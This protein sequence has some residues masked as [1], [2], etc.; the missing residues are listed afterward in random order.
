MTEA[1]SNNQTQML[2]TFVKQGI[3]GIATIWRSVAEDD[4]RIKIIW[5]QPDNE[6]Y[7][8]SKGI[9]HFDLFA[10]RAR[11]FRLLKQYMDSLGGHATV[12]L[13]NEEFD[14]EFLNWLEPTKPIAYI[15]HVNGDHSYKAA[16]RFKAIID[17][18]YTVA[19][20][21]ASYLSCRGL[22]P[23][24]QIDY[25]INLP[26]M[27]PTKK[28][29]I[30]IY[31]GRFACDKNIKETAIHLEYF[32]SKG[33]RSIWVGNGPE[34]EVIRQIS[35]CEIITET[36]R[37]ELY[38]L[39]AKTRFLLLNS[40]YEGLPVVL[41]ECVH[42]QITP[43]LSY[44]DSSC[45]E[46]LKGSYVLASRDPVATYE[47]A[48]STNSPVSSSHQRINNSFINQ[49][50]VSMLLSVPI[51]YNNKSFR[52]DGSV[53]DRVESRPLASLV[54]RIRKTRWEFL[55]KGK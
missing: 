55:E 14:L 17:A 18:F 46:I 29:D 4:S 31:L 23:V 43:I 40:Y 15:A 48:T 30:I 42:F 6:D 45:N 19:A 50:L 34:E 11:T 7:I 13:A 25:S 41:F 26:L 5:Y 2:V 20:P 28:E 9:F 32:R 39:L 52:N 36:T 44:V 51:R 47:A 49:K 1:M 54:A 24:E 21:A 10:P 16:I 37:D 53:V 27:H 35:N 3:G 33:Y 8:D 38:Q 22:S 12:F